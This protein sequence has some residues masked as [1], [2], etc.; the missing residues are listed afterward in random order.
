MSKLTEK[1]ITLNYLNNNNIQHYI[2]NNIIISFPQTSLQY[3]NLYCTQTQQVHIENDNQT[4]LILI[5]S[6][7]N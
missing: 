4:P 1:Q 7:T 6:I 2:Q 5:H 3:E